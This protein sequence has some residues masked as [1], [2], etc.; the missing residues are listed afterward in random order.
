MSDPVICYGGVGPS[1]T[2]FPG[3]VVSLSYAEWAGP[4]HRACAGD[5][6]FG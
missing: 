1:D 4:S 2:A 6:V 3:D 5:M